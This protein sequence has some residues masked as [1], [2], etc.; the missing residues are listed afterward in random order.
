MFLNLLNFFLFHIVIII[1]DKET[2]KEKGGENEERRV[3]G[4][5]G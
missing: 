4:R 3:E 1:T 2:Q 5:E